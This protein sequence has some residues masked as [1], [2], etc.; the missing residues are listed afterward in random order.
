MRM[1]LLLTGLTL[2]M[3]WTE[4]AHAQQSSGSSSGVSSV[5]NILK[6]PKNINITVQPNFINNSPMDY[7]NQNAPIG[8]TTYRPNT[9]GTAFPYTLTQMFYQPSRP[10][11][12]ASKTT[13][14]TSIF[15]TPAQMRAAA[16]SYFVPFQMYRAAPI[17]P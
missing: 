6:F 13:F 15:P 17:Q 10:N 8:T 1:F 5:L 7:R 14:G 16:P 12:I 4:G 11:L 3:A 9:T 2:G